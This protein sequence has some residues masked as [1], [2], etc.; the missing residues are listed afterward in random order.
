MKVQRCATPAEPRV[1]IHT[2]EPCS[3]AAVYVAA[4][5]RAV[6]GA[7]AHVS[8]LC[9]ENFAWRDDLAQSGVRMVCTGRRGTEEASLIRRLCR[10]LRF[11]A[12]LLVRQLRAAPSC[13][14]IH[15]QFPLYFPVG[16][17][18]FLAAKWQGRTV[19]YTAHDPVPHKWLLPGF[20]RWIEKSSLGLAYRLSDGVVV[21]SPEAAALLA[22]TFRVN[23]SR[24]SVIPHGSSALDP[25]EVTFPGPGPV[26]LLLF[27]SIREDKGIHLAIEAVQRV[28]AS[29]IQ[30]R[31]VIA[32]AVA[33]AR[34]RAY[35]DRCKQMLAENA[36]GITVIEGFVAEGDVP[37]LLAGAHA[38][39]LP[40]AS[41]T[42]DSGVA[43]LALGNGRPI[44]AT[45]KG[46][47]A[48]LFESA[49]VGVPIES[50]SA[51][52]VE[53]VIRDAVS[54]GA[55][56]LQAK[57]LAGLAFVRDTRSWPRVGRQ[58]FYLYSRL[59]AGRAFVAAAVREPNLD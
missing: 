48:Q 6:A 20:L 9:P 13:D 32:G 22:K 31:L 47:F 18:Y 10:N 2:P 1:L 15:F 8:V 57:G 41:A 27:G 35:W 52:S 50:A 24:I 11:A 33:N 54:L 58:T 39:L 46:S 7:G 40:Y 49:D 26:T 36:P 28:N 38:V 34:E 23:P 51:G 19:V 3:G 45:N 21:H 43:F 42:S 56:G 29:G 59:L 44:L 37:K 30:V 55:G 5:A 14:L 16:T 4:I 53:K 25:S 12:G 17:A